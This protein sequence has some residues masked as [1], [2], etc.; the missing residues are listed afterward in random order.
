[1]RPHQW[2]L[3]DK[4]PL[5]LRA[6][7]GS[8]RVREDLPRLV[9]EVG[10]SRANS[11]NRSPAPTDTRLVRRSRSMR[12]GRGKR[13]LGSPRA[14]IPSVRFHR[15]PRIGIDQ[16]NFSPRK[17]DSSHPKFD[18]LAGESGRFTVRRRGFSGLAWS[19]GS[20]PRGPAQPSRSRYTRARS[21]PAGG[22]EKSGG[23]SAAAADLLSHVA[24]E[25][26]VR[27]D[28]TAASPRPTRIHAVRKIQRWGVRGAPYHPLRWS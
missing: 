25:S 16:S 10:P 11:A 28:S 17:N 3:L 21:R 6:H 27:V 23:R 5:V 1:M 24:S 7:F 9:R 4:T 22:P 15:T 26:A 13:D 18:R 12:C 20:Y 19:E 8:S 2:P 14:A